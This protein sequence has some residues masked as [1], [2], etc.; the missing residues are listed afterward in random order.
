MQ[1]TWDEWAV[2]TIVGDDD[3]DVVRGTG[4]AQAQAHATAVLELYGIA[5][6]E[7]SA[8]WGAAFVPDDTLTLQLG[9][10]AA[11][12]E[13]MRLQ[14]PAT[15]TRIAAF[16]DGFNAAC[17]D[18]VQRGAGRRE[19]LPVTPRD[20][21]AHGLRVLVRFNQMDNRQ[22][23]F[24]PDAFMRTA[25]S[26]GWAVSGTRSST[27]NAM[28][29]INPHLSWL[30][31]LAYHRFF[32]FHTVS[33]GRDFY[34]IG[35]LGAPWQSMGYS[36]AVG[37][38]HTVNPIRNVT[39]FDLALDAEDTY[40]LDGRR[41]PVTVT[42]HKVEVRDEEPLTVLQRSSVHGPVLTAPDGADV[43]IRMSGLLHDITAT[44][45]ESWWQLSLAGTV[46]ELLATHDRLP[47]PMFNLIAAD[48]AGSIAAL[49]CGTPP[50]RESWEDAD[51]R[52]PGS[53]SSVLAAGVHP[54]STMPRSVNPPSGWVQNC[55]ENPWLYT[56]PP[57]DPS[58][59]PRAIAPA[60]D[61]VL[62]VRCYASRT[63]LEG[64]DSISPA[65]LRELKFLKHAFLADMVLDD[66]LEAASGETDLH[67]AVEILRAWDREATSDSPGY[68][69]FW[70]WTALNAPALIDY[71]LLAPIHDPYEVPQ[72]LGDP[73]Q[74]VEHLRTA[75]ATLP[76]LG[77]PLDIALGELCSVGT[78]AD[79]VPAHGGSGLVGSLKALELTPT[80]EGLPATAGDTW[81]AQVELRPDGPPIAQH[82]L[83]YGNTTEPTAPVGRSQWGLW[84]ADE[85]RPGADDGENA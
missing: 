60:F 43:A 11:T 8:L 41:V 4:Y 26:N 54:A 85:L 65:D 31:G 30:P 32:E 61:Q 38:G 7:A 56:N 23:A 37:W 3:D 59:Y 36:H 1:I 6:G 69:L 80:A 16:C 18:D 20:V 67:A 58:A 52:V 49:Y 5:R 71:T 55:N 35:L 76:L 57:L 78:G 28:V 15:L 50:V 29:V 48:S 73:V 27:G 79:A 19:A 39:V 62:D 84:S 64:R 68:V 34:G 12:D 45:L 63:W 51:R 47:L 70:L 66:L 82:L 2:P 46:E 13:W 83:V 72:G 10:Q 40:E 33:P 44:A 81:I 22:L 9:L 75:V 21:V 42:E 77:I 14:D 24:A 74:A 17:D 53:D 25:G